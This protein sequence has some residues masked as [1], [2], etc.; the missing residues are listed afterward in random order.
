MKEKNILL[1]CV[2]ER[3]IRGQRTGFLCSVLLRWTG[4]NR[5][6]ALCASVPSP[7]FSSGHRSFIHFNL[8]GDALT[9][10]VYIRA[11]D[12]AFARICPFQSSSLPLLLLPS[13]CIA[14][15]WLSR[16]KLQKIREEGRRVVRDEVEV[17]REGCGT[18]MSIPPPPYSLLLIGFAER[19]AE[20]SLLSLE[21]RNP[22]RFVLSEFP[23]FS[24]CVLS[25]FFD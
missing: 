7:S 3:E 8:Q 19:E 11:I 12:I 13:D 1:H 10:C 4:P 21:Q 2:I 17:V 6:K 22:F 23:S 15:Q 14:S 25:F 20:S 18:K 24:L 5:C 9:C 16:I